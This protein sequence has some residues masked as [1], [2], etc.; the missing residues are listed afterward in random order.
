MLCSGTNVKGKNTMPHMGAPL[1]LAK[2]YNIKMPWTWHVDM[3]TI[4]GGRFKMSVIPSS[5]YVVIY[6][7]QGALF[8]VHS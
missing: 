1:L 4:Y 8:A 2:N 7:T 6:H 3:G 5:N